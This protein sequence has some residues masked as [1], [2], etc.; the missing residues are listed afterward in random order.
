VLRISCPHCGSRDHVEFTYGG[1]AALGR[2][3]ADGASD[4]AWIDFVYLRTNP[5]DEHDELWHHTLGC[6]AW[7]VVRRNT[8]THRI[9][10]ARLPGTPAEGER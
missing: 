4:A 8:L 6:R 10:A 5:R 3:P 1:D 2:P 9:V 7:L